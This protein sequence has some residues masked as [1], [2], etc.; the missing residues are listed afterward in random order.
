VKITILGC[1]ASSGTPA[2]DVGWGDCDPA[3]PKNRRL[4]P[5]ILVETG[6]TRVLVDTSPDLRQQLLNAQIGDLDA[7]LFTHGHA[8]H[9]HGIDD[10]RPL[11]RR[12]G[13]ALDIYADRET[14]DE[15]ETRFGYVL[16]PLPEGSDFFYKPVL[17]PHVIA[18]GQ[19]LR[20]GDL[21]AR[22]FGQDH[23]YGATLG[24]RFGPIAYSTDLVELPEEAFAVLAGVQVWIIGALSEAPHPTH[25]H[26]DKAL[27]WGR[28]VGAPRIVL[29]HLG[30]QLD[31]DRLKAR[32]PAG[33]EPA[34]D[35]L[36]ISA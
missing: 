20:I 26:V 30:N 9:L 23:G 4:R 33:A 14:L 15:I 36:T 19:S 29:T 7:I 5:S 31:Y 3:N 1:G 22:V 24:Y 11:N 35:G 10:L 8:D 28:R 6:K 17:L 27:A 32:L 34:Y 2:V 16:T 18:R 21:E 12:L 25:A 13:R